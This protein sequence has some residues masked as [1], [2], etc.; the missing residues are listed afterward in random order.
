MDWYNGEEE[1]FKDI[2]MGGSSLI[3]GFSYALDQMHPHE[4]GTAIFYS[5]G[6]YA[7]KGSG[8]IIPPYSPLRFDIEI[9]D[10]P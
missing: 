9:V 2:T 3:E 6:G 8:D 1:S 4:S 10:K 7:A 5:T